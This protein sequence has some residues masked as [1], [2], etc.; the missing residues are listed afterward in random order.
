MLRSHLTKLTKNSFWLVIATCLIGIATTLFPSWVLMISV[1]FTL[2]FIFRLSGLEQQLS[3]DQ[4]RLY[5]AVI[6]LYPVLETA[7]KWLIIHGQIPSDW[8]WVNRLEHGSWAIATAILF[9]PFLASIW[10]ALTIGQAFLFVIG[11]V[12][13]FGNLNECL[14]YWLTTRSGILNGELLANDYRETITDL[15]VNMVGATIGFALLWR[16]GRVL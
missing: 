8:I 2:F 7:I 3:T 6:L 5:Y 13:F 15:I 4:Q 11:L 12:C 14:E 1:W 10:Q 9:L 16:S